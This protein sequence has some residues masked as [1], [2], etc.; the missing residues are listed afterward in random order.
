MFLAAAENDL[1]EILSGE[2]AE[3][4]IF[5]RG[6]ISYN[7]KGIFDETFLLIDESGAAVQSNYPRVSVFG[8]NIES[9]FG[10]E[11]K[12][13]NGF[14]LIVKNKIFLIRH[15]ERDGTGSFVIPL[16]FY[17]DNFLNLQSEL[18]TEL[19]G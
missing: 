18:E 14:E 13:E 9:Y 15:V 4:V 6:G 17:A 16:R 11:L 2:F 8:K 3:D 1:M 19:S 10:T 12:E 5:R 7:V